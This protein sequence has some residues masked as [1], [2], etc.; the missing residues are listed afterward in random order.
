[1]GRGIDLFQPYC[2]CIGIL[3]ENYSPIR[4]SLPFMGKERKRDCSLPQLL[5]P[6]VVD[7]CDP[8]RLSK[9]QTN[10]VFLLSGEDK[11]LSAFEKMAEKNDSGRI[12]FF[13]IE[14]GKG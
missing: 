12:G 5:D 2:I 4:Q 1:M 14:G 8:M 7:G 9:N 10:T 11:T 13:Q 3:E 6:R